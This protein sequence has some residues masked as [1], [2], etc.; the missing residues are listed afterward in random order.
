M[1][2]N[3]VTCLVK[4]IAEEVIKGINIM[5]A[6]HNVQRLPDDV[7]LKKSIALA[8]PAG[9]YPADAALISA[10][11]CYIESMKARADVPARDLKLG[12]MARIIA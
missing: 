11:M 7:G 4:T 5:L 9:V 2:R 1:P 6:D 8:E 12:A 3:A 10:A